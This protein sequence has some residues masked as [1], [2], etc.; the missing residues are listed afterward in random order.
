MRRILLMATGVALSGCRIGGCAAAA[1]G[2]V[3]GETGD[4]HCDRRYVTPGHEPASFCQEVIDTVAQ[5]QFE[6]DCRDSHGASQ[7]DGRCP[8]DRIIAGCELHKDNDDGSKIY[9]WYYDVSD[10]E[11]AA[12]H[13]AAP[14][15]PDPP[16][17]TKDEIKKLCAD[18]TRYDEGATYLE[19]PP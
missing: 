18:P 3:V 19:T 7:G 4:A 16:V 8:R 1:L 17:T 15:F 13:D 9:D 2:D 10:L 5:S 11:D 14:A 12:A 6:S